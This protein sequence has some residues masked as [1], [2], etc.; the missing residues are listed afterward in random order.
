[1]GFNLARVESGVLVGVEWTVGGFVACC[2]I[3]VLVVRRGVLGD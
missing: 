3:L 2:C 1:M